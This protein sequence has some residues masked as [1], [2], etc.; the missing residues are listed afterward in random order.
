MNIYFSCSITGGRQDQMTYA[1]IVDTLIEKGHTVLTAHL[2]SK[3]IMKAEQV[4][5]P[6][7]VYKRDMAW[8]AACDVL[9]AEVSTPSHGVGYEIARAIS[10][11]KDVLCCYAQGKRVSKILTGNTEENCSIYQYPS[12]DELLNFID[13]YLMKMR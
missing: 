5:D 2:A 9:I 11:K 3:D 10:L 7:E 8:V 4:V 13:T 1:A 6:I 12:T